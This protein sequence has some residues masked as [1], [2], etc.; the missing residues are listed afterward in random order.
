[1]GWS[2]STWTPAGRSA[3]AGWTPSTSE[4]NNCGSSLPPTL[5][6]SHQEQPLAPWPNVSVSANS[7]SFL[8]LGSGKG[9]QCGIGLPFIVPDTLR[10]FS[11]CIVLNTKHIC[12]HRPRVWWGNVSSPVV[13]VVCPGTLPVSLWCCCP[14]KLALYW[15]KTCNLTQT[16]LVWACVSPRYG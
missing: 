12:I 13:T 9:P 16:L 4:V 10:R 2:V 6:K 14:W 15:W 11:Y 7:A 8:V 1:M 3:V 5:H